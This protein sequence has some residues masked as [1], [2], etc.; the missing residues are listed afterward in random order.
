MPASGIE[1]AASAAPFSPYVSLRSLVRGRGADGRA[2]GQ[3]ARDPAA[4]RPD[5]HA[6]AVVVVDEGSRVPLGIITLHDVVRRIALESCD[7]Q[8]PVASVMTGGLI[9]VPAD[10]TAHQASVV[11]VRRGVHHLVLTE[12]TAATSIWCRR[13]ILCTA[14]GSAEQGDLVRAILAA[15]DLPTLVALA[16]EIRAFRCPP[17]C[18]AGQRGDALCQRSRRSTIC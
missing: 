17:G 14:A 2:G 18:R 4:A 1:P 11:M 16:G 12:A 3:R 7:L 9:T 5:A 10:G 13:P 6:D 15:R 8:A